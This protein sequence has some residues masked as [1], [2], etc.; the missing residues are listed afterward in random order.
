MIKDFKL[1]NYYNNI[2]NNHLY[3]GTSFRC[4]E[5]APN[6]KYFN[7]QDYIDFVF[8]NNCLFMC[9]KNHVSNGLNEPI[10][11]DNGRTVLKDET[12]WKLVVAGE[13]QSELVIPNASSSNQVLTSDSQGSW[14]WKDLSQITLTKGNIESVENIE[15]TYV[16]IEPVSTLARS[17]SSSMY[18]LNMGIY[19]GKDGKDGKDGN[20]GEPGKDGIQVQYIY[21]LS[22]NPT[23][24]W[25]ETDAVQNDDYIPSGWSN[26]LLEVT[27]E[28]PYQ[29]ES[30]R[31]K[32]DGLWEVWL[33]PT[34]RNQLLETMPSRL[35]S[36]IF[37]RVP[38]LGDTYEIEVPSGGSYDNPIPS[39]HGKFTY[40][41][42]GQWTEYIPTWYDTV[43]SGKGNVWMTKATFSQFSTAKMIWDTPTLM[44]DSESRQVEYV[45]EVSSEQL[46]GLYSISDSKYNFGLFDNNSY[47]SLEEREKAWRSFIS[48]NLNIN[49]YDAS[50]MTDQDAVYMLE[51]TSV[52][53]GF[54]WSNWKV[55]R[56]KGENGTNISPK[57]HLDSLPECNDTNYKLGDC[58]YVDGHMYI[59]NGDS[60]CENGSCCWTDF[61]D[62][63]GSHVHIKYAVKV[64]EGGEEVNIAGTNISLKFTDQNGDVPGDYVGTMVSDNEDPSIYMGDY[65]WTRW[66]GEDG[67]G[68][69]YVFTGWYEKSTPEMV[70]DEK[71]TKID[72][73]FIDSDEYQADGYRPYARKENSK[74]VYTYQR[75]EDDLPLLDAT[76]NRYIWRAT[77]KRVGGKWGAFSEFKLHSSWAQGVEQVVDYY[78]W[79]DASDYNGAV[80]LSDFYNNGTFFENATTIDSS[81]NEFYWVRSDSKSSKPD[82]DVN[83]WLHNV[84]ITLYDTGH[85]N[86]TVT[87]L[88]KQAADG[89]AIKDIKSYY[90]LSEDNL[91]ADTIRFNPDS[92][93]SSVYNHIQNYKNESKQYVVAFDVAGGDYITINN[94][95]LYRYTE[96]DGISRINELFANDIPITNLWITTSFIEALGDIRGFCQVIQYVSKNNGFIFISDDNTIFPE[97]DLEV[98]NNSFPPSNKLKLYTNVAPNKLTTS[99]KHWSLIVT[100]ELLYNDY[101]TYDWSTDT[102]LSV[103]VDYP[104]LFEK[105]ATTISDN[106]TTETIWSPPHIISTYQSPG[107]ATY[108][109]LASRTPL[110]E[111]PTEDEIVDWSDGPYAPRMGEVLYVTSKM[112]YDDDKE[113]DKTWSKP[114]A[115]VDSNVFQVE[116]S[117][118]YDGRSTLPNFTEFLGHDAAEEEW[119]NKAK[120]DKCGT[121]TDNH[122]NAVYMA[123]CQISGQTAA[124]WVVMKVKGEDGKSA[125]SYDLTNDF[126]QVY[127]QSDNTPHSDQQL[128]TTITKRLGSEEVEGN[129]TVKCFYDDEQYTADNELKFVSGILTWTPTSKIEASKITFKFYDDGKHVKTFTVVISKDT[130]DYDLTCSNSILHK[131]TDGNIYPNTLTVS[132]RK[133]DFGNKSSIETLSTVPAGYKLNIIGNTTETIGEN[134]SIPSIKS[135]DYQNGCT[136][137]LLKNDNELRDIVSIEVIS[138]GQNGRDGTGIVI[139]GRYTT[140]ADLIS[141]FEEQ[142]NSSKE[143]VIGDSFV[144]GE[145]T[146][147]VFTGNWTNF[148]DAFNCIVYTAT[149]NLHIELS[150]DADQVYT[151]DG[152]VLKDFILTTDAQLLIGTE[153]STVTQEWSCSSS[154]QNIEAFIDSQGKLTV[155]IKEGC[156]LESTQ[157][158]NIKNSSYDSENPIIKIFTIYVIEGAED[159]DLVPERQFVKIQTDGTFTPNE[160]NCK[161]QKTTLGTNDNASVPLDTVPEGFTAILY[162]DKGEQ[163]ATFTSGNSISVNVFPSKLSLVKDGIVYDTVHF[164]AYCDGKDGGKGDQGTGITSIQ[165]YFCISNQQPS[166]PTTMNPG[167]NWSSNIDTYIKG[168]IIWSSTLIILSDQSFYWTDPVRS[169]GF[170]GVDGDSGETPTLLTKYCLSD[171]STSLVNNTDW[172]PAYPTVQGRYLWVQISASTSSGSTIIAQYCAAGEKGPAGSGR[173]IYPAGSW[174]PSKTYAATKTTAPYVEYMGKMYIYNSETSTSASPLNNYGQLNA[175]WI[176][177][178]NFSAIYTDILFADFAKVGDVVFYENLMFSQNG[179]GVGASDKD[180]YKNIEQGASALDLLNSS[181]EEYFVPNFAIDCKTG[182]G[183]FAGGK[184]QFNTDSVEGNFSYQTSTT[185]FNGK[186]Y[187]TKHRIYHTGG[188]PINVCL[189]SH[190]INDNVLEGMIVGTEG[191]TVNFYKDFGDVSPIAIGIIDKTNVLQYISVPNGNSYRI[192]LLNRLKIVTPSGA[193]A[194]IYSVNIRP[195]GDS[196]FPGINDGTLLEC[197]AEV[198]TQRYDRVQNTDI[199]V[200]SDDVANRAYGDGVEFYASVVSSVACQ[201]MRV[202]YKVK[203]NESTYMYVTL[204]NLNDIPTGSDYTIIELNTDDNT[205]IYESFI[206]YN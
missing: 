159:Y 53:K 206:Q 123:T 7:N 149:G 59:H 6:T 188:S 70:A 55:I 3:K 95:G 115:L 89:K 40:L 140:E 176:A 109:F 99:T 160:I 124:D 170:D 161:I 111:A 175:G 67:W 44:A 78:A 85:S 125:Y 86:I 5:W 15:D 180:G 19:N 90:K 106:I 183:Y 157:Y 130:V 198:L 132:I 73:S 127:L 133:H 100:P 65:K 34:L 164:E 194:Y 179:R 43:P 151:I 68:Y 17:T 168:S 24:E 146:L 54:T 190:Y 139:K 48:S 66:R 98:L 60:I 152:Q 150:N 1:K 33:K 145:S 134:Q 72:N 51:C 169:S 144:V 126:D 143:W 120:T 80:Q 156:K 110:V 81:G 36:F 58:V 87:T 202:I 76:E 56:I 119:R 113:R 13:A 128:T 177:M 28:H 37:C 204:I 104:Y 122:D 165:T 138:D 155:N 205:D 142:K 39:T 203:K 137:E 27:G 153:V 30:T 167:N 52:D 64:D 154:S 102:N 21:K 29:F 108:K 192:D 148:E 91:L 79:S 200:V 158:I 49:C 38:D 57:G 84:T 117:S 129:Y 18:V 107:Y 16:S 20:P 172:T 4:N 8:K 96:K 42:N 71:G 101:C 77:R 166:T 178:D 121:W 173:I 189:Q 114:K 26:K 136:I 185:P 46:A 141:A 88:Y 135:S 162:N 9:V 131:Y 182:E 105:V 195:S 116:Y 118:D 186:N 103:D 174:I 61:G 75:C 181:I 193:P 22:A 41:K 184:M 25:S 2:D 201:T 191:Q 31:I 196:P 147:Y 83:Q 187:Y 23:I 63:K 50:E 62:V 163:R 14:S 45:S 92:W 10:T 12:Y 11:Y 69:E 35:T 171:S 74:D 197:Y 32:R 94:I 47:N 112:I 93:F 82:G 97:V 199:G